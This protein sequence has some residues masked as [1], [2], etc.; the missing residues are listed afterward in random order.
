MPLGL[1]L[2]ID[3]SDRQCAA[4]VVVMVGTRARGA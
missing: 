1:L 3:E 2:H 4:V